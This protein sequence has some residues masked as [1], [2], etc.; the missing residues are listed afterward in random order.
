MFYIL[1]FFSIIL[2]FFLICLKDEFLS[3]LFLAM[4][5]ISLSLIYEFIGLDFMFLLEICIALFLLV[6]NFTFLKLFTNKSP[7]SLFKSPF[8]LLFLFM[9][10]IGFLNIKK[11]NINGFDYLGEY[12]FSK[13]ILIFEALCIFLLVFFKCICF[14]LRKKND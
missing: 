1:A 5:L 11:S 6:I 4:F 13:N 8:Y 7:R 2:S 14:I 12:L 10:F 3:T 9:L